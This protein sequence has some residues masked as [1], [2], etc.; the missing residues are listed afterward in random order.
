[1]G[2]DLGLEQAGIETIACCEIDRQCCATIRINKKNT[3]VFEKSVSDI[4]PIRLAESLK[5]DSLFILAG[6][7]PCQ[8]FS[9]AGN[10]SGLNDARGNLVFEYFRFVKELRP[11]AF[12]FE[13]VGNILTSA[14]KHRPI[15]LRPGNHWNL[16]K[17][18][19]ENIK[20]TD[21]NKQL[22]DDEMSGSAFRYLIEQIHTLNYSISFGILNAADYGAP[23]KRIRFC[24]L[25]F[26]DVN[27]TGQP[28]AIYGHDIKKTYI[29]LKDAIYDLANNPGPHSVYTSRIAE[30]FVKIPP[31]GN[32]KNLPLED[33]KEILGGSFYSG[34]GKTGFMRRLQWDLPSPTLT[35]KANRK[36]TALCHPDYIRPLSVHEYKRIQGF[37]DDWVVTGAMNQQYQQIGNAVPV[38]LGKALGEQILSTLSERA[39]KRPQS[40]IE[41]HSQMDICIKKLRRYARNN[42]K[43]NN[44]QAALFEEL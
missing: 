29:T 33:Q 8:S 13:N 32:W 12:I 40:L 15:H 18:S 2:L 7:P 16:A 30:F 39:P 36:G 17:Y 35:T 44:E 5:L 11:A 34:G 20:S 6:G 14:L 37:P 24:M 26:R 4:E 21:N 43:G 28:K 9:S 31:G 3:S 25:G 27:E 1:M 22:S 23:Q 19:R 42:T 41:L 10:R 38:Q